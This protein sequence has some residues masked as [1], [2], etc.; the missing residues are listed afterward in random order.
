M[1]HFFHLLFIKKKKKQHGV[2][3]TDVILDEHGLNLF[4]RKSLERYNF[5]V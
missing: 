1:C 4:L 3:G 2:M 5:S